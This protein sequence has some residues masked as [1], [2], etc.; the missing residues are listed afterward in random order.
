MIAG[1]SAAH[2]GS[3]LVLYKITVRNPPFHT[4]GLSG[5]GIT[6]WG[7]KVQAPWSI[8]NTDGFDIRGTNFTIADTTVSNGDQEIAIS[9][10]ITDTANITVKNFGASARA[11]SPSWLAERPATSRPRDLLFEN[12]SITGD[13]PSVVG[14]TVNG[15]PES[16]LTGP[17]HNLKSYAQALPNATGDL[18]AIQITT[19]IN[20]GA[21][22][23]LPNVINNVAFKN[24]CIQDIVKPINI[25]PIVPFVAGQQLPTLTGLTLQNVHMLPVNPSQFPAM[26]QGIPVSPAMPGGYSLVFQ[27]YP[28]GGY[29]NGIALDNVV[30]DDL[31]TGATSIGADHGDRQQ[32]HDGP[33][34]SILRS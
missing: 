13:L 6:V 14:T 34:T 23:K 21:E 32:V 26:K 9:T 2:Q 7:M 12:I 5:N 11:V 18:K 3:N 25:T 16:T 15:V 10:F 19:N 22:S 8:P 29:Y 28:M 31:V 30:A 17:P 4:I 27:A 20:A 1:G 33:P 24:V